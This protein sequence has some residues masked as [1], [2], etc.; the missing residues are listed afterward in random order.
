MTLR[1]SGGNDTSKA[2]PSI[3]GGVAESPH[4]TPSAATAA[5]VAPAAASTVGAGGTPVARDSFAEPSAALRAGEF[6]AGADTA[7]ASQVDGGKRKRGVRLDG[8]TA[9]SAFRRST[10]LH[11][12]PAD[13]CLQEYVN[14]EL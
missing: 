8:I 3:L 4:P 13:A 6:A 14:V 7:L 5:V 10:R 11:D 12:K 1:P 9:G 2:S